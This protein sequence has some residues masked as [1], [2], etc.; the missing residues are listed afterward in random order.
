MQSFAAKLARSTEVTVAS[1]RNRRR[2]ARQKIHSPAYVG[3]SRDERGILPNLHEIFDISIRGVSFQ[4]PVRLH[5]GDYL[6]L[7]LDLFETG[8][9]IET[10]ARVIWSEPSGRTGARFRKLPTPSFRQLKEWLFL[11]ALVSCAYYAAAQTRKSSGV[12]AGAA[13][14]LPAGVAASPAEEPETPP[15]ADPATDTLLANIRRDIEA[16]GLGLDSTLHLLAERARMF[17]GANGAAVAIS[18]GADMVCRASAG[19]TA[20]CIGMRF[21]PG[22]GFSGECVRRGVPLCCDDAETDTRVERE[23]CQALGIRSILAV[24]M[25]SGSSVIGL[26]EVFSQRPHAFN[27]D[28]AVFLEGLAKIGG[29]A[30]GRADSVLAGLS[31]MAE[32]PEL[33]PYAPA[34]A[35]DLGGSGGGGM[36]PAAASPITSI[37]RHSPSPIWRSL[38]VVGA[39]VALMVAAAMLVPVIREWMSNPAHPSPATHVASPVSSRVPPAVDTPPG[40]LESLRQLAEQGDATAQFALGAHYAV[41]DGVAQDYSTA[42]HWFALAAN[43]GHVAAQATLGAYYWSGT[44][45]P[46]DLNKAYFWSVLA[47]AG[48]DKAS[49]YRLAALASSMKR[50]QIIAAQE[51]AEEWLKGRQLDGRAAANSSQ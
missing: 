19:S 13:S 39:A 31:T 49:K 8:D 12:T 30:A 26:L 22:A 2:C 15:L 42:A 4:S 10:K 36:G 11:N 48:G 33:A 32:G 28:Q 51:E 17:T 34:P 9:S 45:I 18:S 44:G 7:R 1:T 24:P 14:E 37:S 46:K 16:R 25:R 5:P 3:L 23:S 50:R 27:R 47:Q 20:P 6:S 21:Q 40:N 41:G 43:Q 35:L 38:F 29:A